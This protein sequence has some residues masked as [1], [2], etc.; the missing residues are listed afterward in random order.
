MVRASR[1]ASAAN[2]REEGSPEPEHQVNF[3]D[4]SRDI[5]PVVH[6]SGFVEQERVIQ[7][8]PQPEL[9]LCTASEPYRRPDFLCAYREE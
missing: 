7:V 5:V 4:E 1:S 2:N 3:A 6:G 9:S 8:Q